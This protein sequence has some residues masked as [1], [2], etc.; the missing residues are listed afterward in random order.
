MFP[1]NIFG[2]FID[3]GNYNNDFQAYIP[4]L[5]RLNK[6]IPEE[7]LRQIKANFSQMGKFQKIAGESGEKFI[8]GF[9]VLEIIGKGAYGSVYLVS[10]GENQYAMKEIP[11]THFDVTPE[12]FEAYLA[13]QNK[14]IDG[15]KIDANAL[16]LKRMSMLNDVIVED[17]CKEVAILKDLQ[18]PNI[19]KYF[20]SFADSQ[21]IYIIM[22][23]L[24]GY[25]L[26]DFIL[27]QSEK[28]HKVKEATI[29]SIFV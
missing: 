24:D 25:S 17:I 16:N 4:M 26:A 11:L 18:H 22:E 10:R 27:S 3:V 8:G 29:W 2:S 9:K 20:N 12:K 13:K 15:K 1:A 28:K 21:N 5:K 19:I 14:G 23:L 7:G 6:K